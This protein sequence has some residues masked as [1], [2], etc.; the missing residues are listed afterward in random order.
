MNYE[1]LLAF[2]GRNPMLSAAL[3][4]LT[5]AIIVTEIRRLFRGFKGIKPAELT[6]L[7]NAG[8]TVVVDLSASGD[9]EKGHIAGSRNA[10][11]S[12]FGPDN[13]LVANAKQSPVVLVCRSG[14]ASETAA[15]ALKKAG[16]EK[17]YLLD[18]GIPAWQQAE[19]PLVKGRN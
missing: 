7:M 17:V 18:G 15:K 4:G 16:F 8:G 14:N 19:L 6:Q 9:F 3:V 11:A 12:A 2:A 10:Q 13:K 1:E 5:V